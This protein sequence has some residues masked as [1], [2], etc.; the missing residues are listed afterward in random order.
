MSFWEL[1]YNQGLLQV[2]CLAANGGTRHTCPL[3][4]KSRTVTSEILS[5]NGAQGRNRPADRVDVMLP[6]AIHSEKGTSPTVEFP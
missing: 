5:R 3:V 4:G 2:A 1:G 6:A